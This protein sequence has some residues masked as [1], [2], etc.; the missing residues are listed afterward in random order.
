M[1]YENIT[2]KLYYEIAS[3]GNHELLYIS[4]KYKPEH[5]ADAWE[6]I[7]KSNCKATNNRKYLILLDAYKKHSQYVNE[8]TFLKAAVI[9]LHFELDRE[10]IKEIEK[11]FHFTINLKNSTKYAQSLKELDN[12]AKSYNTKISSQRILI[13]RMQ[14]EEESKAKGKGVNFQQSLVRVGT[15]LSIVIPQ[16]VL[17]STFNEYINVIK[18]REA[19]AR[20][21]A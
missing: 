1:D 16:D 13:E 8:Q 11:D 19:N 7:I 12:R 20:R 18:Q 21:A 15:A 2:L 4:G 6:E 9:K 5:A 10:L 14:K 3:T 17:L